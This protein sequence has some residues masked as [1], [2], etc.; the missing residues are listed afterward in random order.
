MTN[1]YEAMQG[2]GD[3]IDRAPPFPP[4]HPLTNT[5]TLE[6]PEDAAQINAGIPP[7][8]SLTRPSQAASESVKTTPGTP[9]GR[10]APIV[11][12]NGAMV[13]PTGRP[14]A[15]LPA[16]RQNTRPTEADLT[17]GRHAEEAPTGAGHTS[18]GT[19]YSNAPSIAHTA[20]GTN[21]DLKPITWPEAQAVLAH[22]NKGCERCKGWVQ[23][24]AAMQATERAVAADREREQQRVASADTR[25]FAEQRTTQAQEQRRAA[26]IAALEGEARAIAALTA[27]AKRL[28]AGDTARRLVEI[29]VTNRRNELATKLARASMG[30]VTI[31]SAGRA[32]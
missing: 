26:E 22:A 21:A 30:R 9:K 4:R 19:D 24:M 18:Y 31:E 28:P 2:R 11:N 20:R 32:R 16:P 8:Q 13:Y 10:G 27:E 3:R 17:P 15:P 12:G 25:R 23:C 1:H 6:N 14:K 7:A 5:G 29:D